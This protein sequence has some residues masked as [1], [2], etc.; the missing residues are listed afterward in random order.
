MHLF[1]LQ[2]WATRES[3]CLFRNVASRRSDILRDE[4]FCANHYHK[5]VFPI[6]HVSPGMGTNAPEEDGSQ[7][8]WFLLAIVVVDL[9]R[10]R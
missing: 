9:R 5:G 1:T 7:S 2:G 4:I 3:P 6:Q 10:L 8:F